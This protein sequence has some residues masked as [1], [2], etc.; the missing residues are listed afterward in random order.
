MSKNILHS[1]LATF[2]F[3]NVIF[4]QLISDEQHRIMMNTYATNLNAALAP[5]CPQGLT[6]DQY[7]RG[8]VNGNYY[9]NGTAQTSIITAALP[10][11]DY[12]DKFAIAKGLNAPNDNYKYFYSTFAPSTTIQNGKL[13]ESTA[14][15]TAVEMWTCALETFGTDN[16]GSTALVSDKYNMD[17]L[18]SASVNKLNLY[19]GN[20][21]VLVMLS[22]FGDCMSVVSVANYINAL[23]TFTESNKSI[24][25]NNQ[26]FLAQATN[27]EQLHSLMR[28]LNIPNFSIIESLRSN[29]A[30][31]MQRINYI[32]SLQ[33]MKFL[34]DDVLVVP[35]HYN[36]LTRLHETL[37]SMTSNPGF[38]E[39]IG[40]FFNGGTGCFH[41]GM[42]SCDSNNECLF[43]SSSALVEFYFPKICPPPGQAYARQITN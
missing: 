24:I 41:Y 6:I 11:L 22:G 31:N 28:Q 27:E 34:F 15:L 30:L 17:I 3:S 10:L 16:C 18:A 7:K 42:L 38:T 1:L 40:Y 5:S 12:G 33:T 32:A 25:E 37:P 13:V 20:M 39:K 2:L 29:F 23:I 21:G 4:A 9:L 36:L 35:I 26:A 14:G 8:I 19:A 43:T